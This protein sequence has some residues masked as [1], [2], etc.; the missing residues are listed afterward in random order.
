MFYTKLVPNENDIEPFYLRLR[1]TLRFIT[2]KCK[3]IED[4]NIYF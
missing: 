3:C 1:S 4:L 2:K